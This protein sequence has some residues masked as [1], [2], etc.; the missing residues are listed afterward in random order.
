M[1]HSFIGTC[2]T[3]SRREWEGIVDLLVLCEHETWLA[4]ACV[5]VMFNLRVLFQVNK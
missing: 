2:E 5:S 4:L 1:V 3:E